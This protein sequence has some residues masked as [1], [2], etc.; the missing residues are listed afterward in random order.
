VIEAS[1]RAASPP[2]GG[3]GRGGKATAAIAAIALGMLTGCIP[4]TGDFGRP[5]PNVI[6]DL[7]LP[8]AG[9]A[10]ARAR[11]EPASTYRMTDDEIAMRDL[12]WGV[13][14]PPL[15]EQWR[16]RVLAEL[17]RTRV[18]PVNRLRLDKA[19][20]VRTLISI[21]YSSSRSR[22]ER[23][24]DDVVDDTRRVEPFFRAAAKVA[25]GDRVRGRALDLMPDVQP[26]DRGKAEQR[27]AEN[28]L[29]I[30][31]VRDSFEERLAAYRYALDRLTLETPDR[32]ALEAGAAIDQF[33]AVLGSLR[34]LA[35]RGVFKG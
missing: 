4:Q 6:D 32:L 10:A 23:L 30:A 16:G 13:V 2:C 5:K 28:G 29:F 35:P 12:A 3:D 25:E 21:D 15:D 7:A 26:D 31:W 20:Y 34:P 18:L 1:V 24:I 14:M 17:K 22:Y 33:A 9:D 27:I 11:G 19:N 8:V